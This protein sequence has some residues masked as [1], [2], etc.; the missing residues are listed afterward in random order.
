MKDIVKARIEDLEKIVEIDSEV[1]GNKSRQNYIQNA[2][3][4]GR[5]IVA[6]E[7]NSI[8]GFL[9]YDTNFFDCA[10]MSLII[11][12]PSKRRKGYASYMMDYMVNISP[13]PKIFSSTNRSNDPMQQVFES[14][15]FVQSGIIENLDEGDP[16]IV[17]FK[18]K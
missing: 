18:S 17:Y 5:C 10:F 7:E 3:E 1:I 9:T 8:V 13:T 6:I 14:N 12:S 2:I 4:C 11:V 16:E 15:G